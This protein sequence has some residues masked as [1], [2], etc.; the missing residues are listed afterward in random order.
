MKNALKGWVT[1]TIGLVLIVG[2]IIHFF[3]IIELPAPDGLAGW[4]AAGLSFTVGFV[5]FLV[6]A[7]KLEA[8]L[9]KWIG[10]KSDTL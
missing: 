3:G 9:E 6:P 1:S 5:L 10:K 2:S 4:K 8:H 7:S